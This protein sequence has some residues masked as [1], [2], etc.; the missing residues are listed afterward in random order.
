MKMVKIA[1]SKEKVE[2]MKKIH[3]ER[4]KKF[5]LKKKKPKLKDKAKALGARIR[6]ANLFG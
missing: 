1:L 6:R 2:R 4:K 3:E 5:G